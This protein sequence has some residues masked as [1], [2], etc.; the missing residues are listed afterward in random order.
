[1]ITPWPAQP[2]AHLDYS[3]HGWLLDENKR[4][5]VQLIDRWNGERG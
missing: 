2:P 4:A 1:M 3:D 5:V